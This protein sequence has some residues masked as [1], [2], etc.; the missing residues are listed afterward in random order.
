LRNTLAESY[1]VQVA[2]RAV[3][4]TEHGR[5]RVEA[6][7]GFEFLGREVGKAS[8][9]HVPGL[10]GVFQ[11]GLGHPVRGRGPLFVD[12]D[13]VVPLGQ[14]LGLGFELRERRGA[15]R[16]PALLGAESRL[17]LLDPVFRRADLP[18]ARRIGVA[19]QPPSRR[20][21]GQ[22]EHREQGARDDDPHAGLAAKPGRDPFPQAMR[23]P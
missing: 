14:H 1:L 6:A 11:P 7:A 2:L 21:D 8:L 23:S 15:G 10:L 3:G 9:A 13:L 19:V 18:R 5:H 16:Q 20:Y 4:V 22:A 12:L 17:L